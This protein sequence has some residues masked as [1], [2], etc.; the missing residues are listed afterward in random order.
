[1]CI[2]KISLVILLLPPPLLPPPPL[3][4]PPPIPLLLLL[5]LFF[6]FFFFLL[7]ICIIILPPC[8]F[9]L[10]P[11]LF[12]LIV[13]LRTYINSN[14]NNF[15]NDMLVSRSY[16]ANCLPSQHQFK[17]LY[18]FF[19]HCNVNLY[20]LYCFLFSYFLISPSFCLSF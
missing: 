1:M 12:L 4:P 6:L 15:Q 5:L 10:L 17:F 20:F 11:L 13:Y 16:F 19:G 14:A 8:F 9:L 3:P 2:S 7:H 18:T